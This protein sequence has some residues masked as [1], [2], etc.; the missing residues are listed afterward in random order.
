MELG[1]TGSTFLRIVLALFWIGSGV[2]TL[3][4]ATWTAAVGH[5][6][7]SG[8]SL[9]LAQTLTF[10]GALADIALGL[11]FLVGWKVRLFGTLQLMLM[12]FY[13]AFLTLFSPFMWLDPFGAVMKIFPA[14]AATLIVMAWAEPR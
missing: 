4:P 3:V 11:P 13:V 12:G 6:T 8:L 5:L 14:F 1:N 7:N 2:I 10:S 9:K